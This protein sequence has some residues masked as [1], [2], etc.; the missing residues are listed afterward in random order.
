MIPIFSRILTPVAIAMLALAVP[1]A[2]AGEAPVAEP[3]RVEMRT[4]ELDSEEGWALLDK[5][6][7]VDFEPLHSNW[8]AQLKSHCGAASVVVVQNAL[9]PHDPLTQNCLFIEETAHI[10]TQD[11]VYRIGFTLEEL[12]EMIRTRT[13]LQAERFHAGDEEGFYDYTDFR[14]ALIANRQSADDHLIIN[15]AGGWIRGKGN[16]GGH[17]S[18]IA[19]FNEEEN[20]VLVLEINSQRPIFWIDARDLWESMATIDSVSGTN[21]GWIRVSSRMKPEQ[22]RMN[23]EG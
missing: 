2:L 5:E 22:K 10:I 9:R 18:P 8:V 7:A 6:T 13:G 16:S 23:P 19:D 12:T 21:R 11:V 3:G 15:F 1:A 14:E 17:F 20:M 4:V